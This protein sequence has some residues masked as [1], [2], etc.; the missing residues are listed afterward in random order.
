MKTGTRPTD[1]RF[2]VQSEQYQFPYHWLPSLDKNDRFSL[3]RSL[4]WGL[5]YL[6]YMDF[7]STL[8]ASQKPLSIL[9]IGCGDGR[10]LDFIC[11]KNK[12][13]KKTYTG[14]DLCEKAIAFARL[15]NDHERF[16]CTDVA[17]IKGTFEAITLIEVL[18]HIPDETIS[19]FLDI[20]RDR[21]SLE[22]RLWVSVPSV[23]VPVN[24]KH[25]RHYSTE[26]LVETLQAAG[27]KI[28]KT[29]YVYKISWIVNTLRRIVTNRVYTLNTSPLTK[30]IWHLHRFVGYMAGQHNC[31]HIVV[32]ASIA[33]VPSGKI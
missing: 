17:D 18:E 32:E 23:N 20:V 1:T 4:A 6:T 8:I 16:F 26:L 27:F 25:Y 24:E 28:D 31:M 22:G 5:D 19:H 11:E 3:A 2:K 30:I 13:L 9:D 33:S 10:F 15:L 7:I 12:E 14:V 21:L 29:Y